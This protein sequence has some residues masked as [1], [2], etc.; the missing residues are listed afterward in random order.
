MTRFDQINHETSRIR[1]FNYD[2]NM[3]IRM[4]SVK[5]I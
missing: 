2:Q 3:I 5:F 1:V 4:M